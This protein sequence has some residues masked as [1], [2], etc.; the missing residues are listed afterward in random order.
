MSKFYIIVMNGHTEFTWVELWIGAERCVVFL[1]AA[2][3]FAAV[4]AESVCFVVVVWSSSVFRPQQRAK[5][6][7]CDVVVVSVVNEW[8]GVIN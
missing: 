1:A 4:T 3:Q 5:G 6:F 7:V 8:L 2:E